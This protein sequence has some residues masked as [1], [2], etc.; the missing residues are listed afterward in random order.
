MLHEPL[1]VWFFFS[2]NFLTGVSIG[3]VDEA[4]GVMTFFLPALT[5][6]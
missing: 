3:A 1:T 6:E 5:A 2:P 4:G